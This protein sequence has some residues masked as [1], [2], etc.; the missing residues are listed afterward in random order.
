MRKAAD[1]SGGHFQIARL[2][3]LVGISD[4][5]VL[6]AMGKRGET[7]H[8]GDKNKASYNACPGKWHR[9]SGPAILKMK[10]KFIFKIKGRLE[11]SGS[12]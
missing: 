4:E 9:S 6:L 3:H 8:Q 7:A 2:F 12:A 1:V 11:C 5:V 10:L